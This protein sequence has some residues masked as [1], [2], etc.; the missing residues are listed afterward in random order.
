MATTITTQQS[1]SDSVSLTKNAKGEY[2][3]EIKVYGNDA[4]A[5]LVKLQSLDAK[6]RTTYGKQEGAQ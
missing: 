3:W 6:L 1:D 5:L 2:Q 4:D